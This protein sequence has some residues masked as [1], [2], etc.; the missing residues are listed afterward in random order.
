MKYS[1]VVF[2][3]L[4]GLALSCAPAR[5]Q[6]FPMA[7]PAFDPNAYG[8][9]GFGGFGHG[10]NPG[11]PGGGWNGQPQQP[12]QPPSPPP[13]HGLSRAQCINFEFQDV[14]P[15]AALKLRII[16]TA[17]ATRKI[18]YQRA[19]FVMKHDTDA[20]AKATANWVRLQIEAIP[21]GS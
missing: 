20:L 2:V 5:A 17:P 1:R 13:I 8:F 6:L 16:R 7:P 21:Q 14:R 12:P 3:M 4:L 9:G 19:L 15:S 18:L 10:Y 11:Y